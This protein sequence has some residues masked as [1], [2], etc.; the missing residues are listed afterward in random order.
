[1]NNFHSEIFTESKN[2]FCEIINDDE[3]YFSALNFGK[4]QLI[5]GFFYR[6]F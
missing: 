5:A 6:H 2:A 4:E 1:M 3:H